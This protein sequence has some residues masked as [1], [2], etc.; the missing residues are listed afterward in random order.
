[1]VHPLSLSPKGDISGS[2]DGST[3]AYAMANGNGCTW[4]FAPPIGKRVEKSPFP[5]N[6]FM[7][8]QKGN[9]DF[10]FISVTFSL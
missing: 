10:S 7:K 2:Y 9:G 3:T 1:M 8:N 4:W 5:R 6:S